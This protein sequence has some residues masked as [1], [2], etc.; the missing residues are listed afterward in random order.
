MK[1][2]IIATLLTLITFT[3]HANTARDT[4]LA[5]TCMK[6]V[7]K[8]VNSS[9]DVNFFHVT[10]VFEVNYSENI[11]EKGDKTFRVVANVRGVKST[12]WGEKS[13]VD[14]YYACFVDAA[15]YR[16]VHVQRTVNW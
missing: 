9:V 3:S 15:T 2:L 8:Q 5:E 12:P 1:T 4:W 13:N 7:L 11:L 14:L 10:E 6:P 16:V